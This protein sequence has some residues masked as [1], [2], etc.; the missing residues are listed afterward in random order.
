MKILTFLTLLISFT[1]TACSLDSFILIAAPAMPI[2]KA[3]EFAKTTGLVSGST[4]IGTASGGGGTYK[5]QSSV[6]NYM[7]VMTQTTVSGT[8]KVYSSTQGS[9]LSN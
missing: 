2:I 4:Q 6:G 8:Y 5:V 3:Q 1:T 7:S 9:I